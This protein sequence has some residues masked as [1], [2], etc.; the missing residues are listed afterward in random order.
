MDQPY[1]SWSVEC[2]R[3]QFWDL[4]YLFCTYS[5]SAMSYVSKITHIISWQ[6]DSQH[7]NS[8]VLQTFQLLSLVWK[9]ELNVLLSGWVTARWR[10]MMIKLSLFPLVRRHPQ[11]LPPW[12]TIL[13][14]WLNPCFYLAE[15]FPVDAHIEHLC[16]ILFCQLRRTRWKTTTTTT[17]TTTKQKTKTKT[18]QN[19]PPPPPENNNNQ[20]T[21]QTTT[22]TTKQTT[23]PPPP[24]YPAPFSSLPT[25]SLFLSYSPS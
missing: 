5:L 20:P 8:S 2:H 21:N 12:H 13:S 15:T 23:P 25:N 22:T 10:Q 4:F 6:N 24:P 17:T 7:H 16:H 14:A 3:F 11:T 18:K 19:N 9:I 1:L